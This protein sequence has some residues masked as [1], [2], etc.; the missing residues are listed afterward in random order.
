MKCAISSVFI[1]KL[2]KKLKLEKMF[3]VVQ[4]MLLFVVL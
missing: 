3:H 2:K 1:E 4:S